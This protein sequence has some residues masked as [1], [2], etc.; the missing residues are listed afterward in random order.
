MLRNCIV[1]W[2]NLRDSGTYFG[3][4]ITVERD[5]LTDP[6]SLVLF[7]RR[8]WCK[9]S[10]CLTYPRSL[11]LFHSMVERIMHPWWK[12]SD[13]QTDLRSFMLFYRPPWWKESDCLTDPRTL[14]LFYRLPWWRTSLAWWMPS[15]WSTASPSTTTLLSAWPPFSSRSQTRWS[16]R[17]K[18]TSFRESQKF[19]NFRGEWHKV[20][21]HGKG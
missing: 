7:H 6:R 13:C 18:H 15:A 11:V 9:D 10:D 5:C 4:K 14:V 17:A 16:P 20:W 3:T 8:Q 2:P 1:K 21:E 12:D 19:G